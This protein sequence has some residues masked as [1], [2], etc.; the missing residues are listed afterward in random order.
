M[1]FAPSSSSFLFLILQD[2]EILFVLFG[3][4]N[5]CNQ[6]NKILSKYFFFAQMELRETK[7]R[8][9]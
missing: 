8:R 4:R 6:E 3:Y 2:E 1:L 5:F 7:K 9:Y